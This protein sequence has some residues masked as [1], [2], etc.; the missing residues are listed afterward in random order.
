MLFNRASSEE[1]TALF[2]SQ[3]DFT[4]HFLNFTRQLIRFIRQ[5]GLNPK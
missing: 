2:G 1:L 5:N 3:S 4:R